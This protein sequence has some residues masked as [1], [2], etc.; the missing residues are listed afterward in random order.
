MP[1]LSMLLRRQSRRRWVRWTGAALLLLGGLGVSHVAYRLLALQRGAAARFVRAR[2][3]SGEQLPDPLPEGARVGTVRVGH[4]AATLA[5]WVFEPQTVPAGTVLG[6]HGI[7]DGKRSGVGLARHLVSAGF[8]VVLPDLRGHG[9]STGRFVTFGLR[10]A[11]D[12][13]ALLDR[14]AE[15]GALAEPVGVYGP[16]YGG[17][18]GAHLAGADPRVV[19]LSINSGFA[20]LEYLGRAYASLSWPQLAPWLP[21]FW[22]RGFLARAGAEAGFD[23][24]AADA[25]SALSRSGAEVLIVHGDADR[26]IPFENA[27]RLRAACPDRCRL[28]RFP[29]AGHRDL[30]R[31]Q[32][33][34][35]ACRDF[36]IRVLRRKARS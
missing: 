33:A 19:A 27:L 24:A 28:V 20:D 7:A 8:R 2:N 6:L 31:S 10:E 30:M 21:A 5:Y 11:E 16:S 23:P 3:T 34:I 32:A 17:A 13:K 1:T 18:V 14:L 26:V 9:A 22:Y 25:A 29:G 35:G 15:R 12:L 36:L 4:P